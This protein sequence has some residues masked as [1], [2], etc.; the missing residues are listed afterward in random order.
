MS[1]ET[2][3]WHSLTL[4]AQ[5]PVFV[6]NRRRRFLTANRAWEE[7]AA[8][9]AAA[10]RGLTCTRRTSDHPLAPLLRTLA[11]PAEVLQ[12]QTVRVERPA[13]GA[14]AG[15]PWWE[16]EFAPLALDGQ[17]LIILGRVR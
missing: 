7:L 10:L 2:T 3:A 4:N 11:P 17:P 8:Q 5:T 16:V 9:P 15:P 6:L 12:G 14:K 13:P 1:F